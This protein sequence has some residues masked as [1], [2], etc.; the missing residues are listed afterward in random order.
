M[1]FQMPFLETE[2]QRRDLVLHHRPGA[3]LDV[4]ECLVND[5][6]RVPA[7]E[8]AGHGIVERNAPILA[9]AIRLGGS[10]LPP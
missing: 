1:C 4:G 7:L 2:I 5:G 6:A 9:Q 10:R 8:A 3:P